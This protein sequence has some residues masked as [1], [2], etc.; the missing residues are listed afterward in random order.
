[1]SAGDVVIVSGCS[2]AG[3]TSLMSQ[4]AGYHRVNRDLLGGTLKNLGKHVRTALASGQNKIVLDNTFPTIDSRKAVIEAAKE[5]GVPIRCLHLNTDAVQAKTNAALRM[6]SKYGRLM[7]S[8]EM[9]EQKK[10]SGVEDPNLFP[11]IVIDAYFG[12]FERP[13]RREGFDE[14][15]IVRFK[16]IWDPGFD[17]KAV[18][19]DYDGT[20]RKTK[21]GLNC[22]RDTTDIEIL[23]NRRKKLLEY[24]AKGYRL[25]G[26]SNQS[27]V[28]WGLVSHEVTVECFE[29]T[30]RLLGIDI[31]YAFCPHKSRPVQCY[32]RKPST[33]LGM[34]FIQ[35]YRLN[36][37]K[38]IMVGDLESDS[39]FAKNCGFKY[40]DQ[41]DFFAE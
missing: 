32:C 9:A 40:R 25:L 23:P 41:G 12:K 11:P 37:K 2:A 8:S 13:T 21:S 34:L 27:N 5:Y 31:E 10:T 26:I 18:I 16:R 35:K 17:G 15:E 28:G 3:K 14:V 36:P 1:M 7:S 33:G 24:Q 38:V 19:L 39:D 6:L 29:E 30:N 22:P 4:F 20:L